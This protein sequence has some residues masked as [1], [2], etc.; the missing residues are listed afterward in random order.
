MVNP[1][2]KH[3]PLTW[4]EEAKAAFYTLTKAIVQN[5]KLYF[6]EDGLP[7]VLET[8]ACDQG[9]GAYL[10]QIKDGQ[11]RPIQFI[12]KVF[13]NVQKRWATNEK[14]A[15]VIFYSFI[16]L[17]Y[18]LRYN[19]F[20]LRTDHK[21]LIYINQNNSSAK[22]LRW[23]L[24]IQEFD[25]EPEHVAGVE[26]IVADALSR[27]VDDV[28]PPSIPNKI[29]ELNSLLYPYIIA[30]EHWHNIYH[31]HNHVAGHSGVKETLR[32]LDLMKLHWPKRRQ[33][34][35]EFVRQCAVCQKLSY[36]KEKVYTISPIHYRPCIRCNV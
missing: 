7:L 26:N 20:L 23:K 28:A 8:D 3:K 33:H 35:K 31:A 29:N 11:Q 13:N 34:V 5:N 27:I 2:H 36:T 14:E 30:D 12:S 15:Y 24:A 4:T 19:K 22:V 1:Y 25:Y 18:I 17:G 16:E 6:L 9:M 10:Y 21:N 32:K